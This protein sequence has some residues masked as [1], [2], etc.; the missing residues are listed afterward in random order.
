M[1]PRP[2]TLPTSLL[3]LAL[4]SALCGAPLVGREARA[5]NAV[6]I[7]EG[8]DGPLVLTQGV[9]LDPATGRPAEAARAAKAPAQGRVTPV[10]GSD[11]RTKLLRY[12]PTG[13]I[14][15]DAE[16]GRDLGRVLPVDASGG[17]LT[18]DGAV[19]VLRTPEGLEGW[20]TAAGKRLWRAESPLP[21]TGGDASLRPA[22]DGV[23]LLGPDA[24]VLIDPATGRHAW[25]LTR[26]WNGAR[27]RGEQGECLL[28]RGGVIEGDCPSFNPT[29]APAPTPG[30]EARDPLAALFVGSHTSARLL[31]L[32]KA[33][34][35]EAVWPSRADPAPVPFQGWSLPP[36]PALGGTVALARL[37]E[38]IGAVAPPSA[39]T[40]RAPPLVVN[41]YVTRIPLRSG[42]PTLLMRGEG[43]E[44]MAC[45]GLWFD[46]PPD[47]LAP[48]GLDQDRR[49]LEAVLGADR[50]GNLPLDGE[51]L[52]VF[53]PE[54]T[55]ADPFGLAPG[56]AL[57]VDGQGAERWRGPADERAEMV[58]RLLVSEPLPPL[59]ERAVTPVWAYRPPT[60][61]GQVR[62]VEGGVVAWGPRGLVVLDADGA[63][64]WSQSG[65]DLWVELR[66]DRLVVRDRHLGT[67]ETRALADGALVADVPPPASS[68]PWRA[69]GE[70]GHLE[71]IGGGPL[72]WVEGKTAVAWAPGRPWG[73][74]VRGRRGYGWSDGQIIAW[75]AP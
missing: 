58:C 30:A 49:T 57:L 9:I 50:Q 2:N 69:E 56:Q 24:V 60:P 28:S 46:P 16:T 55:H 18:R 29:P 3:K 47:A 8:E 54:A 71:A 45:D 63:L 11:R 23:V 70:G 74:D 59:P 40:G 26:E 68:E 13:V 67:S 52:T 27:L 37:L 33:R 36:A 41:G 38:A 7:V 1:P 66:G 10:P 6:S 73:A 35:A 62:A 44:P 4:G 20:S 53:D 65:E 15:W 17:V 14:A 12:V 31:A 22:G 5:G 72:V 75:E 42:R 19:A 25:T 43:S 21:A 51:P 32:S 48:G 61:T 34:R 39:V 64:R